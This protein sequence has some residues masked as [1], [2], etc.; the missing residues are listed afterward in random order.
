MANENQFRPRTD[1]VAVRNVREYRA[2]V[3]DCVGP[4]DVVLEI[5]CEWG[6]T[7]EVLAEHAGTVIGTDISEKCIARA[8]E[9]HPEVRFEVLDG[10]DVRAAL[11]LGEQF[12]VVYIDMSGISG[13]RSLMDCIALLNMY[14]TVLRPRTIVVKS[15]A[16]KNFA[17]HC[18]AWRGPAG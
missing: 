6:T 10:F 3:P 14:A 17:R 4:D 7:T 2:T 5:G 13:Y 8:R 15:G 1:F 16:L 9:R 18:T 11:E 12:S